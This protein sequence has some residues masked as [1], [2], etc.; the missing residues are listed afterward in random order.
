VN[1]N[2]DIQTNDYK[3][4]G[5]RQQFRLLFEGGMLEA[6]DFGVG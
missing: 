3:N 2:W 5:V 6:V 4:R 1:N